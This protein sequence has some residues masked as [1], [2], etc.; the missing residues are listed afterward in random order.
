LITVL[1]GIH[2][3]L[4][5]LARYWTLLWLGPDLMPRFR[6]YPVSC[7]PWLVHS[8]AG[9]EG[10]LSCILFH[11]RM[12]EGI[13]GTSNARIWTK[14]GLIQCLPHVMHPASCTNLRHNMSSIV[15]V[16]ELESVLA[17]MITFPSPHGVK[18]KCGLSRNVVIPI[19]NPC[20]CLR[21]PRLL[22]VGSDA[23][24]DILHYL[25]DAISSENG[26]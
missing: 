22:C 15:V 17:S 8:V 7:I 9:L 18:P 16:V 1:S 5:D 4:T 25:H 13:N 24:V 10:K 23:R 3:T 2:N 6:S 21:Q 12:E 19:G 11:P 14:I 20:E 26:I